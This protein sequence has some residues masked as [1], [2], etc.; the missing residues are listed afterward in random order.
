M[1]PLRIEPVL[2]RASKRM[3]TDV[4]APVTLVD[5]VVTTQDFH[6]DRALLIC[7]VLGLNATGALVWSLLEERDEQGLAE[8]V[9]ERFAVDADAEAVARLAA[10]PSVGRLWADDRLSGTFA[11]SGAAAAFSAKA[12]AWHLAAL[13]AAGLWAS[14]LDGD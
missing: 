13:G 4:E 6:L 14:G 11:G 7:R 2:A 9:S 10:H 3:V 5:G 8:A 12:E 1:C